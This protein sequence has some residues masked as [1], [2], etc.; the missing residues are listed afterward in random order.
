[1]LII[2][3]RTFEHALSVCCARAFVISGMLHGLS[4]L[5][6]DV[7]QPGH[8]FF[9]KNAFFRDHHSDDSN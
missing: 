4:V 8:M 9:S 6:V 3:V 1:M 7:G 2:A 5:F